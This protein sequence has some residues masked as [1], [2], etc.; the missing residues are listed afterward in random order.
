MA[1]LRVYTVR[2]ENVNV[3]VVQDLIAI[4]CGASMAVELHGIVLG[5]ITQ[6]VVGNLNINVK[7]LAATVTPGSGG[8][9]PTPQKLSRNDA[10]ATATAHV[11]DTTPASSSGTA[12]LH[13]DVFNPVNGYQF[14]WPP[15]DRPDAGL[16]EALVVSLDT[17]PASPPIA[18]S[19]TLYFAERI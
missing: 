19:G 3:S 7:R 8:T 1:K 11:N 16:S 15:D 4:Y 2:F 6:T 5:Q 10:A 18:M 17:V 14:F 13:S 12:N 9:A